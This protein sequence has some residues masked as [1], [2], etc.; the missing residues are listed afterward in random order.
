MV[1]EKK[2]SLNRGGNI[3]KKNN[4]KLLREEVL[5]MKRYA[6]DHS[7]PWDERYTMDIFGIDS[8]KHSVSIDGIISATRPNKKY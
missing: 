5:K 7:Y 3:M 1:K 6:N 4:Y 8:I 2:K